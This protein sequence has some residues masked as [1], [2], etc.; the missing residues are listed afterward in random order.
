MGLEPNSSTPRIEFNQ[1]IANGLRSHMYA[2]QIRHCVVG[3][4]PVIK[5]DGK[6][7]SSHKYSDGKWLAVFA[8]QCVVVG[9]PKPE[10]WFTVGPSPYDT[11]VWYW[12]ATA[13]FP[14]KPI[15]AKTRKAMW[16]SKKKLRRETPWVK[17][18]DIHDPALIDK[19]LKIIN[20]EPSGPKS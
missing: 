9:F 12:R 15:I 16:A 20:E 4:M 19:M 1:I 7:Y 13:A 10:I 3:E 18:A 17:I 5:V 11:I 6:A 8:G 2:A 14:T